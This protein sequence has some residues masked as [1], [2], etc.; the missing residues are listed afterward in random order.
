MKIFSRVAKQIRADMTLLTS[1]FS[2]FLVTE[3][4]RTGLWCR[5]RVL[6]KKKKQFSKSNHFFELFAR[7][8]LS[9]GEPTKINLVTK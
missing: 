2:N 7:R 9:K 6:G 1:K 5:Y 8:A 3:A 4:R